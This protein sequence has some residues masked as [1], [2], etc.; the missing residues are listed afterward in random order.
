MADDLDIF[1][2]PLTPLERAQA[3]LEGTKGLYE[4]PTGARTLARSR[5]SRLATWC[6][7]ARASG[8]TRNCYLSDSRRG[9]GSTPNVYV[10]SCSAP[11]SPSC[12]ASSSL[13]R[14]RSS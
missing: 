14:S 8:C 1:D 4:A 10:G 7:R 13:A 5:P 9:T 6:S 12:Q 3:A 11:S 2:T